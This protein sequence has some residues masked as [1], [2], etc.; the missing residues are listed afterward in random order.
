MDLM[1]E[2]TVP[3]THNETLFRASKQTMSAPQLANSLNI[4]A[5]QMI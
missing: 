1:T 5:L 4:H 3:K 2:E